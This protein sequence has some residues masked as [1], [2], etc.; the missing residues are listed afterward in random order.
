MKNPRPEIMT[1]DDLA[2]CCAIPKWELQNPIGWG[3]RRYA[4][5]T[6]YVDHYQYF[7]SLNNPNY[8]R[9]NAAASPV[10]SFQC[11]EQ[12]VYMVQCPGS[13]RWRK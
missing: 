8:T 10:M 5:F 1:L 6:D 2:Q 12:A 9:F 13:T 4:D 3:F 11:V 7:S